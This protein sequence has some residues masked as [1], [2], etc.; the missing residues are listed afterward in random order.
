MIFIL[1]NNYKSKLT[2]EA[3]PLI[4]VRM[5]LFIAYIEEFLM[6]KNEFAELSNHFLKF[7]YSSID[8]GPDIPVACSIMACHSLKFIIGVDSSQ[9]KTKAHQSEIIRNIVQAVPTCV[10]DNLLDLCLTVIK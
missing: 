1:L 7:I 6:E 8:P 9:K 3:S 5:M 10:S 2:N 4:K